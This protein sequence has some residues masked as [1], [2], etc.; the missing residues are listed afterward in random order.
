MTAIDL[1]NTQAE[2]LLFETAVVGSSLASVTADGGADNGFS[3]CCKGRFAGASSHFT[4]AEAIGNLVRSFSQTAV[5]QAAVKQ[6]LPW[7]IGHGNDGLLTTGCGQGA[8]DDTNLVGTWNEASWGP[9]FGLLQK[10]NYPVLT[11]L[12]C[13]TGAGED[14]ADLLFAM[15]KRTGKQVRARTGL[16]FCGSNGITYEQGS[17]W[18]V[19]TPT[20]RPSPIAHPSFVQLLELPMDM[21]LMAAEG[22]ED[23]SFNKVAQVKVTRMN[24]FLQKN[25]SNAQIQLD[26][27][28]VNMLLQLVDFARPFQPGMPAAIVTAKIDVVFKDEQ[29][30]TRQFNVYNDRLLQDVDNP[31]IF[32]NVAPGFSQL[33]NMI[34]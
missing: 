19:A 28:D 31:S 27:Q 14:G 29:Y 24:R 23:I 25:A 2:F 32:Y 18:Q 15:A 34:V 5:V 30:A 22:F 1:S 10:V 4:T 12:S 26:D 13:S 33:L 21:K 8:G 9:S 16:T 17:T 7:I 20:Q 11:I 3:G 6:G